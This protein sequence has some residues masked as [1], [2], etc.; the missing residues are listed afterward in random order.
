[1]KTILRNAGLFASTLIL[2]ML[3]LST[4]ASAYVDPA[5]TS[6]IIQIVA[7]AVIACGVVLGVFRRKIA[8]FFRQQKMKRLEK[9]LTREADKKQCDRLCSCFSHSRSDS[10]N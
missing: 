1:M 3:M 4:V 2:T 10:G 8:L 5:V 9:K 6:Y 7:G